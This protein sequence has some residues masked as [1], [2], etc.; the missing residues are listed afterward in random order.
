MNKIKIYIALFILLSYI[1]IANS[2]ENKSS[3]EK[4]F[5]EEISSKN[6]KATKITSV[7]D[8]N[9]KN[10]ENL[11]FCSTFQM[12]W[13]EMCNKYAKGT[14][15]ISNAPNYVDKLNALF[16]QPALL[17]RESYIAM[18]GFGKDNIVQKIN[19]TVKKR[20][21]HLNPDE[22]P[23]RFDFYLLPYD[24]MT[25]AFL[26]KNL[27]F[28]NYF[29]T[30]EAILMHNDEKSFY[31]NAFGSKAIN[32]DDDLRKQVKV[33]YYNNYETV[34]ITMPDG[35][36]KIDKKIIFRSDFEIN[37][38]ENIKNGP[39]GTI[40][41]LISK[42][43]NDEIII[44]TIPVEKTLKDTYLKI[45]KIIFDQSQKKIIN[46]NFNNILSLLAIPN[47]KFNIIHRYEELIGKSV[48]NK[49]LKKYYT[50]GFAISEAIQK[51][52]FNLDRKGAK[53]SSYAFCLFLGYVEIKTNK[54]NIIVKCPFVIY[55]KHK[56]KNEPYFMAYVNNEEVLELFDPSPKSH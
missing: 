23:P 41:S 53:L 3:Y 51:I 34:E 8:E 10:N 14:L 1:G 36:K 52:S 40:I 46:N 28:V 45:N 18:A 9:I 11:I 49:T 15:E 32:M 56:N 16:K 4:S 38:N 27:E 48:T 13:N 43:K 39:E 24:I 33:L 12:A 55:L 17:E 26:Y 37:N 6:L 30:V 29:D 35:S 54:Y 42:S 22:L 50:E 31:A 19:N 7:I 47:L 44:A 21:G 20:F 25:F 2:K 5:V